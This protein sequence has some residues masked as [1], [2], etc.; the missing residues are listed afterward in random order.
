MK[1]PSNFD[2]CSEF[3]GKLIAPH[4]P[5][6]ALKKY[7]AQQVLYK[8]YKN[9]FNQTRMQLAQFL[10]YI[11]PH[12]SGILSALQGITGKAVNADQS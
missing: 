12:S 10:H 4:N 11:I 9:K 6:T 8:E 2:C 3:L 1:L 5:N 7:T